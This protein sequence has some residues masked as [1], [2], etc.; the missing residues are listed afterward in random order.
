MITKETLT[1]LWCT[2]VIVMAVLISIPVPWTLDVWSTTFV[3]IT[4][5]LYICH[6]YRMLSGSWYV[7][8]TLVYESTGRV[9]FW[10]WFM[11]F[12]STFN[13]YIVTVSLLVEETGVP[14]ENH[15]HVASHWELLLHRDM[16]FTVPQCECLQNDCHVLT[17]YT[18]MNIE[19]QGFYKIYIDNYLWAMFH[20]HPRQYSTSIHL[21]MYLQ[22]LSRKSNK[23]GLKYK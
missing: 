9:V 5:T 11:V 17:R 10:L 6:N 1:N 8:C 18:R 14:G 13:N 2:N 12:N 16:P 20:F 19:R 23:T 21:Q 22:W 7:H 4:R 3:A 15:R